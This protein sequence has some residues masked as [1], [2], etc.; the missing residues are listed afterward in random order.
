MTAKNQDLL[1]YIRRTE[2]RRRLE[3]H[4]VWGHVGG[5]FYGL[6]K[7]IFTIAFAFALLVNITYVIY[8]ISRYV[9]EYSLLANPGEARNS[10]VIVS[11]M[12]VLLIA[13]C[14]FIFKR[15]P[16]L[17]LIFTLIPCI[18][19]PIHFYG[20]MTD[21]IS[22]GGIFVYIYKHAAW[23]LLMLAM[24]TVMFIIQAR[25]TAKENRE[26]ARL[27]AALYKHAS[28]SAN[29]T[30]VFSEGDWENMLKN[31]NGE[32]FTDKP[33]SRSEKIRARKA[34]KQLHTKDTD[35]LA[36][37]ADTENAGETKPQVQAIITEEEHDNEPENQE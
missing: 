3:A 2:Y 16:I 29:K 19:L 4:E 13:D 31:Y 25:E 23:Y 10:I 1:N 15:K 11:V 12:S 17:Y 24:M 30:S 8:W 28:A 18:I 35:A 21:I 9:L 7:I 22:G 14:F 32:V 36:P 33:M 37:G 26:Y 5:R 34:Q 20:E 6:A 27:E